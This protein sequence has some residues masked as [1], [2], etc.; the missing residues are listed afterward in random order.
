METIQVLIG[1]LSPLPNRPS[2]NDRRLW[3]ALGYDAGF[4][5]ALTLD[6]ALT[7]VSGNV[8]APPPVT[9]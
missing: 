6:E 7:W 3:E 8:I 4:G 2:L 1:N 9:P 5:R